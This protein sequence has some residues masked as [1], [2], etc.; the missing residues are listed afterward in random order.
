MDNKNHNIKN[1]DKTNAI[2]LAEE[3]LLS[4]SKKYNIT[5]ALLFGSFAKGTNNADSDID[6]ALVIDNMTDVFDTQIDLMKMRRTIDLHIEPHPFRSEDFDAN[7]P[8]V[9][10]IM[11]FGIAL[12]IG[13]PS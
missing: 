5:K 2:K 11:K 7:N 13:M 6:I 12:K 10:E 4:A 3:Y 8:L 1:M 9:N